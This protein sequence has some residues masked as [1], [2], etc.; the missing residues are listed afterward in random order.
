M[1]TAVS[2]FRKTGIWPPDPEV[3]TEADYLPSATTEIAN[4]E[5]ENGPEEP[6]TTLEDS[7]AK[8]PTKMVSFVVTEAKSPRPQRTASDILNPQPQ[9]SFWDNTTSKSN[10]SSSSFPCLSPKIALPVPIIKQTTKR[11]SRK[12]GKTVILTS[13]PYKEELETTIVA[14]KSSSLTKKKG[15]IKKTLKWDHTPSKTKT[16]QKKKSKIVKK[17]KK[18]QRIF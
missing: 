14:K 18:K 7:R 9:C 13:T 5:P 12:R 3:F 15:T 10:D 6:S 1:K 4:V 17:S 16:S 11:V 8:T 2:G